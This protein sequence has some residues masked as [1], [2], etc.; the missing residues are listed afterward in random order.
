[1]SVVV[2]DGEIIVAAFGRPRRVFAGPVQSCVVAH[3]LGD[4]AY[5]AER[6]DFAGE[7]IGG[8]EAGVSGLVGP[9]DDAQHRCDEGNHQLQSE[10]SAI[11]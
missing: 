2:E 1:M 9:A 10:F 5:S 7:Q 3:D 11:G 6:A 4:S 8:P